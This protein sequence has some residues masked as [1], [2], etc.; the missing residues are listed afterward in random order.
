MVIDIIFILVMI[1]AVFKGISKGLVLG[2]FSLL[3]VLIG[4]AAAL[5]LSAILANYLKGN[6]GS[7]GKWIPVLSFILVFIVVIL[8]VKLGARVIEKTIQLAMLGWLNR[9]GGILFYSALY[10][11]IFSI[12]LFYAEKMYLVKQETILQSQVY[13]YI[14]PWGAK[15]I[16]NLG[17]IIPFFRDI[18]AQLEG[19]FDIVAKKAG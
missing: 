14:A 9:L 18:F 6:I 10:I 5:K 12:F 11:I 17:K 19:F 15:V 4:L 1:F 3:T 13:P 16:E 7:F 8:L 2:I